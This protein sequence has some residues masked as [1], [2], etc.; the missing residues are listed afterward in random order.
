[1]LK[2]FWTRKVGK[3]VENIRATQDMA[4]DE[5]KRLT[6]PTLQIPC[7]SIT[8]IGSNNKIMAL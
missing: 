5:R 4:H 7:S 3:T 8:F 2:K 6:F 1:M